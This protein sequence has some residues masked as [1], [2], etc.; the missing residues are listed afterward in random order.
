[1]QAQP[2]ATARPTRCLR[3][4][5][6]LLLLLQAASLGEE[7]HQ[8]GHLAARPSCQRLLLLRLRRR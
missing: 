1:M 3:H 5:P 7:T 2:P 4:P 6:L 8:R